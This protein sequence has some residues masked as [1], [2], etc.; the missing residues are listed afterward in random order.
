MNKLGANE[1]FE[2]A[3]EDQRAI[4]VDL[5]AMVLA[6]GGDVV[7]SIKWSRPCYANS[8]GLF[9]YLH[10]SKNHVTLGFQQGA[11]LDDPNALLE[12][13]GK[14]MRH[15]KIAPADDLNVRQLKSLLKQAYAQRK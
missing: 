13:E 9:C 8:H 2:S 12:G 14:D 11:S 6:V 15:I 1:W 3:P 7:E 10:R 5:R 4:L